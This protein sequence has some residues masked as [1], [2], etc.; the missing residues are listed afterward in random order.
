VRTLG[1]GAWLRLA[2]LAGLLLGG[3]VVVQR[4]GIPDADRIRSSLSGTGLAGVVVFVAAYLACSLL[5]VPKGVLSAGAGLAW[6]F[7]P[8]VAV[9]LVGALLG[10]GAAFWL[11]RWLGRDSVARLAGTHLDRLDDL[12]DRHGVV[13]ILLVRL[14]PLVPF[15]A[16]NYA[17]GLTSI[18]F[19]PYLLGT[20]VGIIPG[21]LAYVALGAYGTEPGSWE[22]LAAVAAFAVL[23]VG[24]GLA[25]RRSR[26]RA[27][28]RADVPAPVDSAA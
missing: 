5:V 21:T 10:A 13:A 4:T 25:F 6:G 12:V 11:G 9:V 7:G 14:V 17:A 16:V 19:A 23:T 3:V 15:T 1:L 18:R 28:D 24:G 26:R 27:S 2:L 22:F 8:G 20:A